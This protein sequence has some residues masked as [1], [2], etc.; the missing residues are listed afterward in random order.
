M[1]SSQLFFFHANHLTHNSIKNNLEPIA[2]FPKM[3]NCRQCCCCRCC[4]CFC[5]SLFS[6]MGKHKKFVSKL[7]LNSRFLCTIEFESILRSSSSLAFELRYD[8]SKSSPDKAAKSKLGTIFFVHGCFRFRLR[9]LFRPKKPPNLD[10]GKR[11][12][13]SGADLKPSLEL[14]LPKKK[15]RKKNEIVVGFDF[16]I[17]H[18]KM[19]LTQN[20]SLIEKKKIITFRAREKK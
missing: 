17:A 5:S 10:S 9:T 8:S 6:I 15:I 1:F 11:R 4:C 13:L 2:G 19:I 20:F 7:V 3:I 14:I 16:G 12:V 18:R